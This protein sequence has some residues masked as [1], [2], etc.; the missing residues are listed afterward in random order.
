MAPRTIDNLGVDVSSRYAN[1]QKTLD[2]KILKDARNIPTQAEVDVTT[3]SFESEFDLL[4]DADRKNT[5]WALFCMPRN[6]GEQR[7]RLFTYQIIPSLGPSEKTENQEKKI[8]E[9][10]QE[11]ASLQEE[12]E[13]ERRKH[14]DISSWEEEQE[15]KEKEKEQKI[16]VSLL[17]NLLMLDKCMAD[18]IARRMQYQKG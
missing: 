17:K 3:P 13:K 10:L 5:P 18:I 15:A 4:F 14:E 6:Y 2:R 11:Q 7:R 12:K 16:L 9:Q 1:D 8:L